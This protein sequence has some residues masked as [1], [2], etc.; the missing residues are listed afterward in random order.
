MPNDGMTLDSNELQR[1]RSASSRYAEAM[2]ANDWV[3]VARFFTP[4]A[5]RMPPNE[6]MHEGR[7]DI[8]AWLSRVSISDYSV[9]LEQIQGTG[10]MAYVRAR[11]TITLTPK[12]A[13]TSVTDAGKA[14]ELWTKGSDRIWRIAS[15]IWNSDAAAS[16]TATEGSRG[17]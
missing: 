11:Y 10:I 9:S 5:I 1:I 3:E 4:D 12:G 2:R 17:A 14:V 15:A 8:I 7:D 13:T 6:P 16:N